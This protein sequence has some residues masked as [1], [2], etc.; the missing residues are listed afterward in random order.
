MQSL[1]IKLNAL[2]VYMHYFLHAD[3]LF[4]ECA[5]SVYLIEIAVSYFC[6]VYLYFE[7]L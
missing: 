4:Q 3:L 5:K 6:L 1:L 2:K 7:F